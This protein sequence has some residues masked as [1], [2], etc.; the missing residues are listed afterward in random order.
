MFAGVDCGAEVD[1]AITLY[2]RDAYESLW[3]RRA[4]NMTASTSSATCRYLFLYTWTKRKRKIKLKTLRNYPVTTNYL[5]SGI[6]H[7]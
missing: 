2:E 5:T 4:W 1:Y 3:L 6:V 7:F